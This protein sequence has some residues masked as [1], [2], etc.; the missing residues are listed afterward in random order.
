M[1]MQ[2]ISSFSGPT[3]LHPHFYGMSLLRDSLGLGIQ[4]LKML[5]EHLGK[6]K[7]NVCTRGILFF[8]VDL[9]SSRG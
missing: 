7:E 9:Y 2:G 8:V 3:L 6:S 1:F 5:R 4:H